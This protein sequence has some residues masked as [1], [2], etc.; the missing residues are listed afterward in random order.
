MQTDD[1]REITTRLDRI[2]Q[3]IARLDERRGEQRRGSRDGRRALTVRLGDQL[4]ARVH[5]VAQQRGC[6]IS[7]LMREALET[8]IP[9][10]SPHLSERHPEHPAT[11]S[12]RTLGRDAAR[13]AISS[14]LAD[15]A[16]L[17]AAG[18]ATMV[19]RRS[20]DQLGAGGLL[21]EPAMRRDS[22]VR[23]SRVG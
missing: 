2:E 11:F 23:R 20:R 5:Q 12:A 16:R 21:T 6:T 8:V 15:R 19:D 7:Q 13:Q 3:Q 10:S 18:A 1:V 22:I 14:N 9:P 17:T 4:V